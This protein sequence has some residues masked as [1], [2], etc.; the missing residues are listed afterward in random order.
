MY[1]HQ[2]TSS[3]DFLCS[4]GG[5]PAYPIVI[6]WHLRPFLVWKGL[7]WPHR[8]WLSLENLWWIMREVATEEESLDAGGHEHCP[9]CWLLQDVDQILAHIN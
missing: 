6:L 8:G 7:I 1:S 3:F 9:S 5:V 4:S 2:I